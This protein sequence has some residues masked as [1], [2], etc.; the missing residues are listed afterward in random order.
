VLFFVVSFAILSVVNKSIANKEEYLLFVLTLFSIVSTILV[1]DVVKRTAPIIVASRKI[2]SDSKDYARLEQLNLLDYYISGRW[3]WR[4]AVGLLVF[5]ALIDVICFSDIA[6]NWVINL[7]SRI[8]GADFAA[9]LNPL[10][11]VF[12]IITFLVFAEGSQWFMRLKTR[13]S[14]FLLGALGRY[15]HFERLDVSKPAGGASVESV[16]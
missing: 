1:R 6:K 9:A 15:Y 4:R 16:D 2:Y 12:L 8:S 10:L 11:V 5:L 3:V 14:I 7:V 13:I